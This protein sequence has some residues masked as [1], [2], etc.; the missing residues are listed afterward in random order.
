M[1]SGESSTSASSPRSSSSTSS[2]ARSIPRFAISSSVARFCACDPPKR[3]R[4]LCSA[5]EISS[6]S[7]F[8]LRRGTE[9]RR[10]NAHLSPLSW[11]SRRIWEVDENGS[12]GRDVPMDV[13]DEEQVGRL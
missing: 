2:S 1:S 6:I 11:E 8:G 13:C 4:G 5:V 9:A 3:L 10:K 7:P 12:S